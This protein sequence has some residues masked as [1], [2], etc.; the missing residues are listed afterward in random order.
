MNL[1]TIDYHTVDMD[2]LN[3]PGI[4]L[5]VGSRLYHFSDSMV[6]LGHEVWAVEPD[7]DCPES[8]NPRI[9]LI[10]CAVVSPDNSGKTQ[11]L[12][13]WSTGEGNHLD[14][15]PGE[16]PSDAKYQDVICNSLLDICIISQKDNWDLIKLDCEG[17][18]YQILMSWPGPFAKQVSVEYHEHTNANPSGHFNQTTYTRILDHMGK[19]YDLVQHQKT[20]HLCNVPNYWDSLFVLR[21]E[22]R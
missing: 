2:I 3:E 10:R 22:F 1:R 13:K 9:H 14:S 11:K 8:P 5:D 18:E 20:P 4:V 7:S 17:A 21:K 12:I 6:S 19:W 15:I 16:R